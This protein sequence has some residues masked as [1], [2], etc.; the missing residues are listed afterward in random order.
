MIASASAAGRRLPS[1]SAVSAS[2]SR[3]SPPVGTAMTATASA[4]PSRRRG[5]GP[6]QPL[7]PLPAGQH[8]TGADAAEQQAHRWQ[9]EDRAGRRLVVE[10]TADPRGD[11]VKR[12]SATRH[13]GGCRP[14]TARY[15]SR[16]AIPAVHSQ[17]CSHSA[18]IA[19]VQAGRARRDSGS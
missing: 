15:R 19:R 14:V 11:G 4:A 9:P 18:A 6:C 17:T 16:R 13:A 12:L 10:L 8:D 3:C 2:P 7:Q 1:P 5:P